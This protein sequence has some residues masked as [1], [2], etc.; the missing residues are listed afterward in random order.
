MSDSGAVGEEGCNQYVKQSVCNEYIGFADLF[1]DA[2]HV[3]AGGISVA[4]TMGT[5]IETS[6]F[7]GFVDAGVRVSGGHETL[8]DSSWFA[9]YYWDATPPASATSTGIELDGQDNYITNVI[10]FDYTKLGVR[11]NGAA[12]LLE[13]VHTWNGGGVGISINGS[14]AIQD[15]LLGC[16][17][18]YNTLTIVDPTQTTVED[19][20]FLDTNAVLVQSKKPAMQSVV[21]RENVYSFGKYGQK[22]S[23]AVEGVFNT[24]SAV[25]VADELSAQLCTDANDWD[26][27][28]VQT[29]ASRSVKLHAARNITLDFAKRIPRDGAR[30]L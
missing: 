28:V 26:C 18:D 3:A 27:G 30:G 16:Y 23:V 21:F 25:T 5:T 24:C 11:V 2:S 19:T 8:V 17:L 6:F 1:L 15:R 29:R 14:Y 22:P 7:T 10:V 9:E 12:T 4:S 20:F 13:G